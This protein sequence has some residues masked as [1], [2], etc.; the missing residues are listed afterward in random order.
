MELRH[1]RYFLV[2]ANELNFTRASEKLFISQPPL[3]R[4]I[5]E[6]ENE[7]GVKLFNRNSKKVEL[8]EAGKF[9]RKE[10]V[11][12]LQNL[13]SVILKTKKISENI[14]GE[15]RIGYIS[16]TFSDTITKLIQFLT[17]KYPYLNIKLYEVSTVKQILALEQSKLDLGIV[18][19]PLVSTKINSK[20][21]FKDS[22][23]LVFNKNKTKVKEID[24]ISKFRNELFV[25]FNKDYAPIYYNS[26]IEIC[27]KY[28]FVPNIV[29]ESNNINSIIQL[30]RNGLGVS[31]VPTSLK[32]SHIYPE[33]SFLD[34]DNNFLTN[35]LL[36]T[37]KNDKS[38]ITDSAISFL[39]A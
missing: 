18:R 14:S 34:L 26:L 38:Q 3:S 22:Y 5:K 17:K 29:H 30:V 4:Q 6:L 19:A 39:L 12:Q 9:F 15:Y 24:D 7:I 36:A 20:L 11:N 28:G 21:W 1:L 10:V 37:P 16:S 25:F 23:S 8:T 31:I 33:L 32:K 13:E 2:V 35:V 27:S